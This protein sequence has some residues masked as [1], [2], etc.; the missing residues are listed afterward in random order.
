MADYTVVKGDNL[1]KLARKYNTTVD[2]LARLNGLKTKKQK[3]TIRIGQT[4]KLPDIA[5]GARAQ[6][7]APSPAPAGD[8]YTILR[9]DTLS[10]IANKYNTTVSELAALNNIADP[11][12]IRAGATLKLPGAAQPSP[13]SQETPEAG[14]GSGETDWKA[15]INSIYDDIKSSQQQ[16]ISG[17]YDAQR[18][19]LNTQKEKAPDIYN[20]L[21]NEAYTNSEMA[22][23]SRREAMA[24]M[25]L[26]A[27]GGTSQ[28]LRQRN[29]NAL[30]NSLGDISRQQQDYT[31]NI[32][33]ALDKLGIQE[34]AERGSS[35]LQ[36]DS[37]RNQALLDQGNWEKGYGLQQ[38]QYGLSKSDSAFNQAF[39][40]YSKKLITKK[41]FESMTG[42]DIR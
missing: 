11:N 33:L 26:S 16:A 15:L 22:E 25:G 31:N 30:L 29:T 34:G 3:D 42:L 19:E 10:A 36:I 2:E 41:Q 18:L 24:N 9:G 4:L 6:P 37:Q 20:P 28:T 1:S 27:G 32:Q 39:E 23:R 21:R 14:H 13:A 17:R 38:S 7:A 5:Q 8:A 35:D 40:L 12:V